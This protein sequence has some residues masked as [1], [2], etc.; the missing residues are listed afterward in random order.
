MEK[1]VINAFNCTFTSKGQK[2]FDKDYI[3]RK[4]V[5]IAVKTGPNDEDYVIHYKVIDKKRPIK[6]SVNAEKDTVGVYNVLKQ[7]CRENGQEAVDE[8]IKNGPKFDDINKAP[9]QDITDMPTNLMEAFDKQQEIN[10]IYA[11]L[12]KELKKDMSVNEF[13]KNVKPEDIKK[14]YEE[15]AKKILSKDENL[16]KKK[17]A[18][19]VKVE[20]T[21]EEIKK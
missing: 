20:P 2:N 7:L 14:F 10:A 21:K 16:L 6:E 13:F 3:D 17:Y 9:V 19:K 1:K 11:Q 8:F 12:P 15:R 18:Q 5:P 4:V